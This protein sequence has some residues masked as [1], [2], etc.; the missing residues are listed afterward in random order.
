MKAVIFDYGGT[1]DTN[2]VHWSE[3]FREVYEQIGLEIPAKEFSLSYTYAVKEMDK[4]ID[5][6][7]SLLQT[8]HKQIYLQFAYLHENQLWKFDD[9]EQKANEAA[10]ICHDDVLKTIERFSPLLESLSKK[11]LLGLVSNYH[12][13][14][15]GICNELKLDKYFKVMI[16]SSV[17]NIW[18]PDPRIFELAIK[19]LN[20]TSEETYVIGDSYDRD[21]VPAKSLGCKTIWVKGKS[22]KEEVETDRADH[23]IYSLNKIIDLLI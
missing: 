9:F 13:N 2:G 15:S 14:L 6:T 7:Y 10:K 3:K 20:V 19:Q 23:I 16:D 5:R 4:F 21:I 22:W 17:V 8:I 11:Y 18:K 1:L 12:G